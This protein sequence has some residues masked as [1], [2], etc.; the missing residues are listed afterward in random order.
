MGKVFNGVEFTPNCE[1][2]SYYYSCRTYVSGVLWP[3][4]AYFIRV[5]ERVYLCI[6]E[7]VDYMVNSSLSHRVRF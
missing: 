2:L 6:E 7:M 5:E 1:C 3:S 4:S